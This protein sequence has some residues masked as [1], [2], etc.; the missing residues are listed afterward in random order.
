MLPFTDCLDSL[1]ND[2]HHSNVF[3]GLALDKLNRND[4]AESAY[5]AAARIKDNDKTA[6]Q[7][8]INLYEKQGTHKLNSYHEAVLKLGQILADAYATVSYPLLFSL[9]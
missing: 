2:D 6:W 3:L 1:V 8:L 9:D 5:L 4:G 7:G